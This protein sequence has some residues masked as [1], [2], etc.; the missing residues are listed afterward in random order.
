LLGIEAALAAR[1]G[2]T[3]ELAILEM[4][5]GFVSMFGGLD[6]DVG[7][8]TRD[9]GHSW[10]IAHSS[11]CRAGMP[12]TPLLRPQRTQRAKVT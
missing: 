8:I 6:A 9:L 2:F 7:S 10:D 5:R 11:S 3:G 1:R 4:D 12:T